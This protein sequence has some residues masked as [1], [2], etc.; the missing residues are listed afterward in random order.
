VADNTR[1]DP[2]RQNSKTNLEEQDHSKCLLPSMNFIKITKSKL[3]KASSN[4]QGGFLTGIRLHSKSH[5]KSSKCQN[6][7]TGWHL[8]K[9]C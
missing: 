5:Q 9:S 3:R 2:D 7:L 4:V 8:E 1:S 6:L